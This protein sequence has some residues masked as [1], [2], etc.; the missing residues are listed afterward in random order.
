MRNYLAS[1]LLFLT[2]SATAWSQGWVESFVRQNPLRTACNK[3]CYEV[4]DSSVTKAP[5]GYKAF[6]ISHISRHG[7]RGFNRE[8]EYAYL[9]TLIAFQQKGLLTPAALELIPVIQAC[10]DR[11]EAL[12]YGALTLKGEQE[13]RGIARR[14][15]R[16][17]PTV[18]NDPARSH[19]SCYSTSSGRV[20]KSMD[21]FTGSL[22]SFYP[23]L[24]VT[25]ALSTESPHARSE[26]LIA[27]LTKE[28][29]EE[30]EQVH[31]SSFRDSILAAFDW[32]RL[33]KA[34]F[35]SGEVPSNWKGREGE[36]FRQ[37]YKAGQIRQCFIL[38]DV[39]WVE[40]YFT[41]DE[42]YTFW[43]VSNPSILFDWG[44]CAENKGYKAHNSSSIIENIIFD[45]DAA[46]AGADTCATFRFSHD[47]QVL[48][49]L[50]LMGLDGN[51]FHGP[52]REANEHFCSSYSIHM[53]GNLQMVFFRNRRGK[54]LVKFLLNEVET[55]IPEL[56][57]DRKG[58]FY[59]WD[60]LKSWL[61]SR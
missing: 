14:M 33:Q 57:P 60:R 37:I 18:F 17:Y 10:K 43:K 34:T 41:A 49:I 58:L 25:S 44:W 6:Y 45:A 27:S 21:S 12:G 9:D 35:L 20:M 28:Q 16:A 23:G 24:S 19:V 4:S 7:S 36:L 53:A 54:V 39:G 3:Y 11:N 30:L 29:K 13:H 8:S 61:R 42:L 55:T 1:A 5:C 48:P 26:V 50:C 31:L 22:K 2:L 56:K 47:S 38:E 15:A 59:D 51:E 46:I 52:V 40:P 32:T